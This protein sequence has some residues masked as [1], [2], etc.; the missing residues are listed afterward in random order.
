MYVGV[1]GFCK[2]NLL[3]FQ[4]KTG[5][6]PRLSFSAVLAIFIQFL[7]CR[8]KDFKAFYEGCDGALLRKVFPE[9][10]CYSSILRR[11]PLLGEILAKFL[12]TSTGTGFFI[13]DSTSFKLCENVRFYSCRLFPKFAA[14]AHSSTRCIFGF[15]LHIAIDGDGKIVA[16]R[17]TNGSRHDI[18]EAENLLLGR[19]GTAIGDKG[20]CSDRVKERLAKNGLRFI[21]HARRNMKNGNTK[22][23]KRFLRRRNSVERVFGKLKRSIGDSFSRFRSWGAVQAIIA[24]GILILNLVV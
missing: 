21:A 23:E 24:I 7:L 13:I 2:E 18:Q 9:M 20:Y 19:T 4:Q 11:L 22:E 17:L 1:D 16:F 5:R 8:K 6:P 10:T 3:D 14:W 15:K 12:Q